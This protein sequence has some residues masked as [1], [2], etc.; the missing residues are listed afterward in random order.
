MSRRNSIID[1]YGTVE[2]KIRST[3][4]ELSKLWDD[5]DMA[6]AMRVNR[7]DKAFTHIVS[8]CDDMLAGEQEMVM[9]LKNTIRENT[10][11]VQKY[12]S[13]LEMPPFT[14]PPGIKENSVA[15]MRHMKTEIERLESEF[16]ARHEKQRELVEKIE[17]L[18][19][20]LDSNFEFNHP[21]DSLFPRKENDKYEDE[22]E[23]MGELLSERFTVIEHLQSEM[24]GWSR[25][26]NA[27]SESARD[28]QVLQ[29]LLTSNIDSES[30][31]FSK[32]NVDLYGAFHAEMKPIYE[33]WLEEMEFRW[34]EKY[35]EIADLWDK[36]M[37]P[38]HERIFAA[39]FEPGRHNEQH[40]IEM[41][42]ECN[43]LRLKYEACKAILDIVEH[44]KSYWNE[45]LDIENRRKQAN[46]YKNTN[47]CEEYD[48][49]HQNEPLLING[50]TPNEYVESIKEEH[51]RELKFELQLKKEERTRIQSPQPSEKSLK[52]PIPRFR[53]PKSAKTEPSAK[54][55]HF[56]PV[57]PTCFSPVTS[58]QVSFITPV[59]RPQVGP[60]TSSPK[61]SYTPSRTA[62]PLHERVMTPS[63]MTSSA[64]KRPLSRRNL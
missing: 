35:G 49:N 10:R 33:S 28:N 56:E 41:E 32:S 23:K 45:K 59:R 24:K 5:I 51:K 3:M 13:E 29:D 39:R 12:R 7:V 17:K 64:S 6:D 42:K 8:L 20:R 15:L 27:I 30:F 44:W 14:T 34:L 31:V 38:E 1:A 50:M 58:E 47:S 4:D 61:S 16:N 11:T 46:Y 9:N 21:I 43:R 40:I 19:V 54:R 60:K 48:E 22:C 36:C 37:I 26:C 52:R 53:T 18:K 57:L 62:T 25:I 2:R 55:I 63:S